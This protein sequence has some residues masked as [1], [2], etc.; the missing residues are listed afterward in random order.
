MLPLIAINLSKTIL[1]IAHCTKMSQNCFI[2]KHCCTH[3]KKSCHDFSRRR[4]RRRFESQRSLD[5]RVQRQKSVRIKFCTKKLFLFHFYADLWIKVFIVKQVF[6]LFIRPEVG[7]DFHRK[8]TGLLGIMSQKRFYGHSNKKWW[9]LRLQ[10]W[11]DS[12]PRIQMT[13]LEFI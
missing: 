5:D 13:N 12:N 8:S 6:F 2:S 10:R 3:W 7:P 1:K 11:M 9:A 4:R